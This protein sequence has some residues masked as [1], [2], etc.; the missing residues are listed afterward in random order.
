MTTITP[1]AR[2]NLKRAIFHMVSMW[3]A[4]REIEIDMNVTID[5]EKI[6]GISSDLGDPTEAFILNHDALDSILSTL[7]A[8][9]AN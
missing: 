6:S 5:E 7:E 4:L 1:E 8:G 3:D 9:D 2:E